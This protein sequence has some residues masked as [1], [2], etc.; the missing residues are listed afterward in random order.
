MAMLFI[1]SSGKNFIDCGEDRL[2]SP[3]GRFIKYDPDNKT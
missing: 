3:L 2:E 1:R